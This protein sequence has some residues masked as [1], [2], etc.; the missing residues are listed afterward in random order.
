MM[1]TES[2][3]SG[4]YW[5]TKLRDEI[6]NCKVVETS[7][8]IKFAVNFEHNASF[9]PIHRYEISCIMSPSD[10]KDVLEKY[11]SIGKLEWV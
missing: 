7:D 6:Y 1:K 10:L 2:Q 5:E 11:F 3:Y 4:E 9:I 8:G